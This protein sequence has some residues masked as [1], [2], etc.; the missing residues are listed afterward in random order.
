M[1]PATRRTLRISDEVVGKTTIKQSVLKPHAD[2]TCVWR[3]TPDALHLRAVRQPLRTAA[4]ASKL[5]AAGCD[6]TRRR[7]RCW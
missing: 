2:S 3:C 4:T 5:R 6:V 1:C 7:R